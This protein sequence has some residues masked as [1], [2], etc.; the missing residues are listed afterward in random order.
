MC[1]RLRACAYEGGRFGWAYWCRPWIGNPPQL[2]SSPSRRYTRRPVPGESGCG[3]GI[4]CSR[5][6]WLTPCRYLACRLVGGDEVG[7]GRPYSQ[8][9]CT[10][11]YTIIHTQTH[12]YTPCIPTPTQ[13]SAIPVLQN[14]QALTASS[15]KM[16]DEVHVTFFS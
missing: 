1:V 5:H 13:V 12:S 10:H 4:W 16:L 15:S 6:P 7:R 14:L 3:R 8:A 2:G 9:T 11:V